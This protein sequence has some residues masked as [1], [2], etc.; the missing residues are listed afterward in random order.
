MGF[1][2]KKETMIGGTFGE[3]LTKN[4]MMKKMNS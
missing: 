3:L 4:P 1:S 2:M